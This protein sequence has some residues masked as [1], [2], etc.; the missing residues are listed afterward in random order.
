LQIDLTG[1]VIVTD[2]FPA[3]FTVHKSV[4]D[5]SVLKILFML[6]QTMLDQKVRFGN[7]GGNRKVI[8]SYAAQSQLTVNELS[9]M[10]SY[11]AGAYSTFAADTAMFFCDKE[12]S[13]SFGTLFFDAPQVGYLTFVSERY[14]YQ[15][16]MKEGVVNQ[17]VK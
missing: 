17:Q 10:E 6:T 16:T 15:F 3:K 14:S 1:S 13:T 2:S 4:T 7:S 9:M 12:M 11:F 5:S 8:G